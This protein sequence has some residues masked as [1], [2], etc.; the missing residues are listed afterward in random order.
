MVL[1]LV[2]LTIQQTKKVRSRIK[3]GTKFI[4][5]PE[6]KEY[7]KELKNIKKIAKKLKKHIIKSVQYVNN[8]MFTY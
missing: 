7:V 5:G 2:I 6:Y 3:P 8:T 1:I 4:E